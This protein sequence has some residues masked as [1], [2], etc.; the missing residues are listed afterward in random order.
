MLKRGISSQNIFFTVETIISLGSNTPD[1][2]RLSKDLKKNEDIKKE[3]H[4][5]INREEKKLVF[6]YDRWRYLLFWII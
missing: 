2:I 4:K 6:H 5:L 3:T 1:L